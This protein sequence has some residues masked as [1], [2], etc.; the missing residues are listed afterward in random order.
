M[1]DPL[2]L[3]WMQKALIEA[4]KG[5]GYVAPNP[6]VGAVIAKGNRLIAKG[7]HLHFGEAH[8]EQVALKRAGKKA[9]NAT[10][11]VTLEPCSTFGKTPP[12]LQA[13]V[14][15][16]IKRVVVAQVDLNP[17]HRSVAIRKLRKEGIDVT[18]GVC[19]EEA[20]RQ[21]EAFFKWIQ[22]GQPFVTVK[23]AQSLDGK[24]A[25][26]T[27]DSKW[28]TGIKSRRQVHQWRTQAQAILVGA[29]TAV[30]DNPSLNAR[31]GWMGPQPQAII[32]DPRLRLEK[33]SKLFSVPDRAVIIVTA[34]NNYGAA[35]EK[36]KNENVGILAVKMRAGKFVVSDLLDK[37]GKMRITSI[38]VEGGARTAGAFLRSRE[39]DKLI[40]MQAP[41]LL[42][43]DAINVFDA[44]DFANVKQAIRLKSLSSRMLGDDLIWEGALK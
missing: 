25:T 14:K 12:C 37:L 22:T 27:G 43:G 36:Y 34:I 16:R 24:I 5:R 33:S 44:F 23:M 26:K 9:L 2:D 11:Y 7:A 30:H 20:Y 42:G 32:L 29:E 41:I 13:I 4:E 1:F 17:A 35:R 39:V 40:I 6:L 28:I 3:K 21:N 19:R 18:V 8:A 10:L 31:Y 38:L 15:A